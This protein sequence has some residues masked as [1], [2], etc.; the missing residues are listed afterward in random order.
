METFT[1][2]RDIRASCLVHQSKDAVARRQ[3][4]RTNRP[5]ITP[6]ATAVAANSPSEE[7]GIEAITLFA[8][9]SASKPDL[10]VLV[11]GIATG[12]LGM[13]NKVLALVPMN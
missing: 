3:E 7:T 4:G 8:R 9:W 6:R 13:A 5:D 2:T 10:E 1:V 12:L 11:A